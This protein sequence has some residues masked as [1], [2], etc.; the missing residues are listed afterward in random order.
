MES[1][2]LQYPAKAELDEAIVQDFDSFRQALN[3]ASADQRVL[4]LI[5]AA[6]QQESQLR[7]SL[8]AVANDE[9]I[10]GRFHFDF[11][12]GD[13][14]KKSIDGSKDKSGIVLINPGEFGMS[15]RVMKYL[16]LDVAAADLITALT[17]ANAEFAKTT[18]KKVYSEHVAKGHSK[19]VY[20][21]GAVP[22]GEDRDG[23]GKIDRGHRAGPRELGPSRGPRPRGR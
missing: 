5:H 23:D 6:E 3:V 20:F 13:A 2:A 11:D 4:V 10:V 17:D 22:Y 14:W 19:G 8:R 15:G 12:H 7:E 16:P 9:G 1:I 18:Q 21:E